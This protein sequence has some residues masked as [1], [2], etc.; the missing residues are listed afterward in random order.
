M[1]VEVSVGV[2]SAGYLELDVLQTFAE[3]FGV[4]LNVEENQITVLGL[5]GAVIEAAKEL[6]NNDSEE[7]QLSLVSGKPSENARS[8]IRSALLD[9]VGDGDVTDVPQDPDMTQELSNGGLQGA[10]LSKLPSA[11]AKP[12]SHKVATPPRQIERI[13]DPD[14]H[15]TLAECPTCGSGGSFCS[16]CGKCI[17]RSRELPAGCPTCGLVNFCVY[18]GQPT[19]R[20]KIAQTR[21]SNGTTSVMVDFND[22]CYD[23]GAHHL[24]VSPKMQ[25]QTMQ[26]M[27]FV[28]TNA[29]PSGSPMVM[30]QGMQSGS[31]FMQLPMSMMSMG[32]PMGASAT[33]G[34]ATS[35]ITTGLQAAT[36][37]LVNQANGLQSCMVPM[38]FGSFE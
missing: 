37:M 29:C 25:M 7:T 8:T 6:Q 13:A 11:N 12:S 36:T 35:G 26:P 3:E 18:C 31:P 20:M 19:E 34:G 14:Q 5:A 32:F 2:T 22:D 38:A 1:C 9:L 24:D 15:I 33:N 28:P 17:K 4:T 30:T 10:V 21:G 16:N 27:Q 23:P